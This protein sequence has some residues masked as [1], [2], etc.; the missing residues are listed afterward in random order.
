M[1]IGIFGGSF[2]PPHVGHLLAAI[3]AT[4]QLELDTLI[5]VPAAQQPHR[6]EHYA[7]PETR[8]AMVEAAIAGHSKFKASR[9]EIDRKGLSFTVD[10][11]ETLAHDYP[12][13]EIFLLVGKDAWDNFYTWH[14][15]DR[16]RKAAQV[17]VLAR[18]V[19]KNSGSDAVSS[20][21][22]VSPAPDH[23]LETRL[24][25]VSSTEVRDR[26]RNN[27]PITGFVTDAVV[28]LIESEGLYTW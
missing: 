27:R 18:N 25:E 15:P 19:G 5:W 4:E 11:V 13:A 14:E 17:V 23:M 22:E 2:D 12:D 1:R 20:G 9:A 24:V 21:S 7:G 28:T 8:L 3:D 16:I 6:T 10:T 26:I